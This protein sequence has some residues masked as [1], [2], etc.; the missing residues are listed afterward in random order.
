M[1]LLKKVVFLGQTLKLKSVIKFSRRKK[2]KKWK[3]CLTV[4]VLVAIITATSNAGINWQIH[5]GTE[6]IGV[7]DD[8]HNIYIYD[9]ALV[10]MDGG[11]VFEINSL[12]AQDLSINAGEVSSIYSKGSSVI[13]V[14]NGNINFIEANDSSIVN[15]RGGNIGSIHTRLSGIFHVWGYDLTITPDYHLTGTWESQEDFDIYITRWPSTLPS[16]VL[17]EIP[18]PATLLLFFLGGVAIRCKRQQ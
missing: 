6:T 9:N 18:E 12:Q 14:N 2:M 1:E 10:T 13:N 7:G 3:T 17:H 8:Y 5:G 4:V 15:L 16:I 11:Q